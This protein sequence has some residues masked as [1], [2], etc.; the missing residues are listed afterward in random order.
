MPARG[1][2]IPRP[3]TCGMYGRASRGVNSGKGLFDNSGV[4]GGS[5][6]DGIERG[7][8]GGEISSSPAR[9]EAEVLVEV[10]AGEA[11]CSVNMNCRG[12]NNDSRIPM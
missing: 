1:D 3:T 12:N 4:S 8:P 11:G 10:V 5:K 6:S 9:V 7:L 2:K